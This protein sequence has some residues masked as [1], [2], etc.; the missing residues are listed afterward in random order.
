[1]K[2][3]ELFSK[4]IKDKNI[5]GYVQHFSIDQFGILLF[6]K[7]Q[8]KLLKEFLTFDPDWP[9]FFDA[10]G[11]ILS[12]LP[13]EYYKEKTTV[14]YYSLVTKNPFK[15]SKDDDGILPICE[16]MTNDQSVYSISIF[17]SKFYHE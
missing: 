6:S 5:H 8:I 13:K 14:Y 2:T 4:K 3:K 15:R 9:I 12:Q 10:T 1:M 17:L 11:K 16:F 7:I